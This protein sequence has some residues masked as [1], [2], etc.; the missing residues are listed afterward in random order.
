[1]GAT[2]NPREMLAGWRLHPHAAG[3][4][5]ALNLGVPAASWLPSD[6][7]ATRAVLQVAGCFAGGMLLA[8][9]GAL[10]QRVEASS[11]ESVMPDR[12]ARV[13]LTGW[14]Q[15][16]Q[17]VRLLLA[18]LVVGVSALAWLP[19]TWVVLYG[20]ALVV[21]TF[22]AGGLAARVAAIWERTTENVAPQESTPAR[23]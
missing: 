16:P 2:V 3:V 20:T 18:L 15:H 12:G 13:A 17:A 5:L 8:S 4:L 1:M 11:D 22:A 10:W 6:W 7:A 19:K 14:R 9:S 23:G 21:G